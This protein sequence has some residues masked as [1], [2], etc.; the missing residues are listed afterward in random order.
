GHSLLAV[1]VIEHLRQ[2]GLTLAVRDLFQTPVLANLAQKLEQYA[3][4]PVPANVI[5]P[6]TCTLTPAM[7][8]L[9]NLTPADIDR[10]VGQVPGG[11]SNLQDIYALSPLQDGILFHHLLASEG[12]PY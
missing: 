6:D 3:A 2:Q 11:L 12:D 9:I 8:P 10:I 1:R 4:V 7:L 5:T